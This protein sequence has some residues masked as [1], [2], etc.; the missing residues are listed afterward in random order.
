MEMFTIQRN[1]N[2]DRS[3]CKAHGVKL[4]LNCKKLELYQAIAAHLRID[5]TGIDDHTVLMDLIDQRNIEL[6]C[7]GVAENMVETNATVLDHR[8]DRKPILRRERQPLPK[9]VKRTEIKPSGQ[10]KPVLLT[11]RSTLAKALKAVLN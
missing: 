8:L 4:P 6:A 2:A 3:A 5:T 7:V 11:S 1:F 9:P 10:S